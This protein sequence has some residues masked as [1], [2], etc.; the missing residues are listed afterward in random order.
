MM[1]KMSVKVAA[2]TLSI[3]TFALSAHAVEQPK[4]QS[5]APTS[6]RAPAALATSMDAVARTGLL[7]TNSTA[8]IG[9]ST[10]STSALEESNTVGMLLAGLAIMGLV[11]RRRMN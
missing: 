9:R 8:S 3:A 1:H 11:A 10:A 2:A 6:F 5:T 7:A 4:I